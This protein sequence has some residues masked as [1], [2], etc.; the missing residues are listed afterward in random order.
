MKRE[1]NVATANKQAAKGGENLLGIWKYEGP[2]EN[3]SGGGQN[4]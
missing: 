3:L 1:K 2:L 4:I